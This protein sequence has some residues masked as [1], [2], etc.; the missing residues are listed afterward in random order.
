MID[1]EAENRRKVFFRY[2]PPMGEMSF[3]EGDEG[4]FD[5]KSSVYYLWWAYL[6]ENDDYLACCENGGLGPMAGIYRDFGNVRS[7]DFGRWWKQTGWKLFCEPDREPIIDHNEIPKSF[8]HS[9]HKLVSI[10]F[11]GDLDR[12]LAELRELL[13][14]R[15]AEARQKLRDIGNPDRSPFVPLYPVV[16]KPDSEALSDRLLVWRHFKKDMTISHLQ[17][18]KDLGFFSGA[19]FKKYDVD[20]EDNI[21][22]KMRDYIREARILIR[23]V[24]SGRFPDFEDRSPEALR[25]KAKFKASIERRRR[26]ERMSQKAQK[27]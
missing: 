17:I 11:I 23:N 6:R 7:N 13:K 14:E 26:L 10:P 16:S 3:A 15:F 5:T 20:Y 1:L 22:R 8:D 12:T 24:G 27:P 25:R 18:A 2:P 4:G 21:E 9:T 19:L